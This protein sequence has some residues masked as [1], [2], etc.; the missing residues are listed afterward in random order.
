MFNEIINN[1]SFDYGAT[2]TNIYGKNLSLS[3]PSLTV[4]LTG[5][6]L[7]SN[8]RPNIWGIMSSEIK[9]INS[10]ILNTYCVRCPHTMQFLIFIWHFN[11]PKTYLNVAWGRG[12]RNT[13]TFNADWVK[14]VF[15][16]LVS[17]KNMGTCPFY[18]FSIPIKT[19][20]NAVSISVFLF[21][22]IAYTLHEK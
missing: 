15:L 17:V 19:V 10:L 8:L 5:V 9:A 14:Y 1:K 7:Q 3:Y 16:M 4:S 18:M 20:N 2:I 22:I 21:E 13:E 6:D 12:G 11:N